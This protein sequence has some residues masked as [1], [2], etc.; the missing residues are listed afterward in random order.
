MVNLFFRE[1]FSG[2]MYGELFPEIT[3]SVADRKIRAVPGNFFYP[4]RIVP[5]RILVLDQGSNIPAKFCKG[6]EKDAGNRSIHTP[7]KR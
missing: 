4:G 3:G 5:I 2:K 6:R 1:N 7:Q